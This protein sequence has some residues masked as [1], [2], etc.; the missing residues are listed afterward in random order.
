MSVHWLCYRLLL[1][2]AALL[3]GVNRSVYRVST[4]QTVE[5]PFFSVQW[6]ES[7]EK[8]NRQ[9][10]L[11]VEVKPDETELLWVCFVCLCMSVL[12]KKKVIPSRTLNSC[13]FLIGT[14]KLEVLLSFIKWAA[15]TAV[16]SWQN[17]PATCPCSEMSY[18]TIDQ[19]GSM[20]Y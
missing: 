8:E 20:E 16:L 9:R 14:F 1:M 5:V 13:P 2:Q 3:V 18:F 17:S 7:F 10:C 4:P 6:R 15:N 12:Q 11:V 19:M